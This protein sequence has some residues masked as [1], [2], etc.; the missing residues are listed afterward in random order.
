MGWSPVEERRYELTADAETDE[1]AIHTWLIAHPAD[2]RWMR[3][4]SVSDREAFKSRAK[5]AVAHQ[6]GEREVYESSRM[7]VTTLTGLLLA[8]KSSGRLAEANAG[9]FAGAFDAA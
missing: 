5:S 3:A 6:K 4:S 2:P 8:V 1:K 7:L 9:P